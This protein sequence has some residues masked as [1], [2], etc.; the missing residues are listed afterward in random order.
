MIETKDYYLYTL[1]FWKPRIGKLGRYKGFK[2]ETL[3]LVEKTGLRSGTFLLKDWGIEV[4]RKIGWKVSEDDMF[5]QVSLVSSLPNCMD[6]FRRL[7][8]D[9]L[10]IYLMKRMEEEENE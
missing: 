5:Y 6:K 4:K 7:S 1:T 9:K 3:E 2:R 10:V 8:V